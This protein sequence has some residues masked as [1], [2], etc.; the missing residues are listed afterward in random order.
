MLPAALSVA[1]VATTVR[2]LAKRSAHSR[3][4]TSSGAALSE[5]VVS[6]SRPTQTIISSSTLG[7]SDSTKSRASSTLR[8][9][10]SISPAIA[11]GAS[12]IAV[13]VM[14]CIALDADRFTSRSER[15]S[16]PQAVSARAHS[17]RLRTARLTRRRSSSPRGTSAPRASKNGPAAS[18]ARRVASSRAFTASPLGPGG[19]DLSKATTPPSLA[20]R[21]ERR[22][23]PSST[24]KSRRRLILPPNWL[25]AVSSRLCASSITRWSYGG[26]ALPP[27][28]RS[29]S[30]R[31][32]F[33][34]KIWADSA[35][36][37]ARRRKQVPSFT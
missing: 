9:T 21:P 15:S 31:A 16:G 13:I 32:W 19:S 33:T 24:S 30:R 2:R 22:W 6:R 17:S 18:T 3:G 37:R 5:P 10:D 34:I 11:S 29:A 4:P 14:T 8:A 12:V 20:S 23:T 26:I 28:A 35:V 7:R 1:L 36:F 25:V 27:E